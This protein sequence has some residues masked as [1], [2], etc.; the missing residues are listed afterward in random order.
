MT[1]KEL[2]KMKTVA[3]GGKIVAYFILFLV[4]KILI[5]QYIKT[6]NRKDMFVCMLTFFFFFHFI[7]EVIVHFLHNTNTLLGS[8]GID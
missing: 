8:I 5:V 1:G 4:I 2:G 7:K 6:E 3:F